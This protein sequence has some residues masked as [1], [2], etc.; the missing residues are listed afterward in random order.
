VNL[1]LET[2]PTC[3][4]FVLNPRSSSQK[5]VKRRTLDDPLLG[6]DLGKEGGAVSKLSIHKVLLLLRE[7]LRE[8]VTN[9]REHAFKRRGW[10]S[11]EV[12]KQFI[13]SVGSQSCCSS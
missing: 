5:G 13:I 4:Y 10:G 9:E 12:V 8:R 3:K 11:F 1:Q 7:T 2:A 6:K